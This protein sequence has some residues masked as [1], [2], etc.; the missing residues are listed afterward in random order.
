MGTLHSMSALET[1]YLL[2]TTKSD[3]SDSITRCGVVTAQHTETS[4]I[5]VGIAG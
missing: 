3:I 1:S 4:S 2:A 5:C